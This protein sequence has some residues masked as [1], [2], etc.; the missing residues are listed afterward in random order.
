LYRM[1]AGSLLFRGRRD[2]WRYSFSTS[3][4]P[5]AVKGKGFSD[6]CVD[7]L[8]DVLQ[9]DPENR[10]SAEDCLKKPWIMSKAPGSEYSIGRDLYER[11][12]SIQVGAPDIN[13][14]SGG[15]AARVV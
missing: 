3:T 13:S 10:P 7:F 14:F 1:F 15:V 6:S 9:T 5:Q 2:V 12:F 11:L 8:G 4:P